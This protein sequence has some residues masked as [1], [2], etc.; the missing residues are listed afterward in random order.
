MAIMEARCLERAV[1]APAFPGSGR[2]TVGGQQLLYGQRLE[3]TVFAQDPLCPVISSYVP[4]VLARQMECTMGLIGLGS[5]REGVDGLAQALRAREE[6]VLVVDAVDKSDLETIAH[7]A[8]EAGLS[9]LTCGSAGLADAMAELLMA[10]HTAPSTDR[11][12]CAVASEAPALVV[13]A[14]RNPLTGLQLSHA[15]RESELNVLSLDTIQLAADPDREIGR[16]MCEATQLLSSTHSVALSAVDSPYMP[17]L[18]GSVA[19][20]LGKMAAR[21]VAKHA[22]A[23]LVLTGGDVALAACAALGAE[24]LSLIGEVAPGIPVGRIRGGP[25]TGLALVTKAGGFGREDAIAT[26]LRYLR[27]P[28]SS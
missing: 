24:A 14:S 5:V 8:A 17:G 20:A 11:G 10:E 21:L 2:T 6:A 26:S 23:G 18:S 12:H 3:D 27:D 22:I 4:A 9:R 25:H 15:A 1:V 13:A 19:E 7:A 16:M 28:L